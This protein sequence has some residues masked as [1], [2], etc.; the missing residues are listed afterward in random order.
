MTL[1]DSVS[2]SR[3][4]L[5]RG[6]QW[7]S[8][9]SRISSLRTMSGGKE[10]PCSMRGLPHKSKI[11]WRVKWISVQVL[12]LIKMSNLSFRQLQLILDNLRIW[13]LTSSTW[14]IT[15][16]QLEQGKNLLFQ[17]EEIIYPLQSFKKRLKLR[18][19]LI[20]VKLKYL[21]ITP[22]VGKEPYQKAAQRYLS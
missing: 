4:R 12:M 3:E 9:S 13:G 20:L 15:H 10:P 17:Q 1:R 7:S 19:I 5:S 22:M 14:L 16:I 8:I 18:Q 6:G 21:V 11:S 2:G